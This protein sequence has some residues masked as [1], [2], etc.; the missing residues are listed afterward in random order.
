M[1]ANSYIEF[2]GPDEARLHS[3]WLT[4]AGGMGQGSSPS[5]LAAGRGVDELV[6]VNG[7]WL[8]Q[9]RNVTPQD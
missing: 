9:S 4:M 8:I 7:E 5:V 6:R 3:Y 2:V 1:I